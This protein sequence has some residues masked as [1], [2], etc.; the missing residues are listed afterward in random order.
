MITTLGR[1]GL[2]AA[3]RIALTTISSS[4]PSL[5]EIQFD[6]DSWSVPSKMC[7]IIN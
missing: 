4:R 2:L 6:V 5:V 1:G 3:T 7:R